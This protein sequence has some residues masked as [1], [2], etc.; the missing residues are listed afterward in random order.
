M[1]SG[2]FSIEKYLNGVNNLFQ[3][4]DV[5][6]FSCFGCE[7][8]FMGVSPEHTKQKLRPPR[9]ALRG[10]GKHLYGGMGASA[11]IITS[12]VFNKAKDFKKKRLGGPGPGYSSGVASGSGTD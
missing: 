5:P 11:P 7:L 4:N 1:I 2:S 12:K 10:S 9:G 3:T 8:P 6:F